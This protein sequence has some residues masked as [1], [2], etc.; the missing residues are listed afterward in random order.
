MLTL[1]FSNSFFYP[2]KPLVIVLATPLLFIGA[3][4][5]GPPELLFPTYLVFFTKII[6]FV[7]YLDPPPMP[8]LVGIVSFPGTYIDD[9]ASV[10]FFCTAE[11]YIFLS[12]LSLVA[13]LVEGLTN[14]RPIPDPIPGFPVGGCIPRGVFITFL[15][16]Y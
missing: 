2:D 13:E 5:V 11:G 9:G 3:L 6:D 7:I 16:F 12:L 14:P 8:D 10:V 4:R 15:G 1:V